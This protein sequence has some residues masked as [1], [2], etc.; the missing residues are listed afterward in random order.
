[1]R[2][3]VS[4]CLCLLWRLAKTDAQSAWRYPDADWKQGFVPTSE[5]PAFERRQWQIDSGRDL[6]S[7]LL[8]VVPNH[9]EFGY[10]RNQLRTFHSLFDLESIAAWLVVT[11]HDHLQ[12]MERFF[13]YEL[14]KDLPG[15]GAD[16]FQVIEDGQCASELLPDSK[17]K[18]LTL[19]PGWTRQQVVKLACASVITTPFYLVLDADIFAARHAHAL[20]LFVTDPCD[21]TAHHVCDTQQQTSYR[22]KNDCYPMAGEEEDWHMRWWRNSAQ[23]LQLDVSFDWELAIGVT[24]QILATDIS[25]QLGQYI[26]HRFQ[27]DSW[28]AYLLEVFADRNQRNWDANHELQHDPAW[29]EYS[30]YYVFA[31]HAGVF[32]KYHVSAPVLQFNAIWTLEQYEQWD[33][34]KDTFDFDYGYLSLV[35]SNLKLPAESVWSR[36]QQCWQNGKRS[37]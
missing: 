23:T 30:I 16:L 29:T 28:V 14:H 4:I 34:C 19:W 11:P 13:S 37:S 17:Y 7:V 6:L 18:D 8:P 32:E 20:D 33:P 35:Q 10:V 26:T 3:F 12:S 36:M 9:L 31:Q 27:V 22:C 15:M 1:M 21:V 2:C 24:P 25:L 5:A